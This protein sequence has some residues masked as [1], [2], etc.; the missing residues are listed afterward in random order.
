[1]KKILL[2]L[3]SSFLLLFNAIASN[4]DS[5]EFSEADLKSLTKLINADTSIKYKT[6]IIHVNSEIKMNV[7]KGYK[8]M[9]QKDA[10]YVV[11]ELWGNPRT[12]DIIGMIVKEDYSTLNYDAW[13]FVVSYENSGYVKD[14]DAN[15]IDYE[16]LMT[17]IQSGEEESNK[18]RKEAGFP[19]MHI[20]G[21][22]STPFYDKEH[23]ILHWAKSITFDESEDTT[24]N[25]DVRILG[26]QGILSLNA[27]GVISQLEDI[28]A[29]IPDI[30][31]IAEFKDGNKYKDFN[32]DYDKVAAYTVGGLIA[33]KLL[34]KAGII[35]LLLKN[36]KLIVLGAIAL[37]GSFGKKIIGFF[38][39]KKEDE[40]TETPIASEP[41][42][43][44]KSESETLAELEPETPAESEPE[45][46]DEPKQIQ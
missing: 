24:L 42:S 15:D 18:Q 6:G 5:L 43:P 12:E 14:E 29:H 1:M 41:E 36:I 4:D 37:F 11:F 38:R 30:I 8:F 3:F 20:I 28:K 19:G 35:A 9:S 31:N 44:A 46:N 21:W 25:Y 27:V 10:E 2:L 34:A 22:A 23:N 33:G 45:S 13:A 17:E 26:R 40:E 16:E 7:P 39:R 32:P